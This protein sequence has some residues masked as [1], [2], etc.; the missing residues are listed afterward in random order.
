[1]K[2]KYWSEDEDKTIME[3]RK[4]GASWGAVARALGRESPTAV[5]NRWYRLRHGAG[6]M[7]R[8]QN[9]A[10]DE[11]ELIRQAYLDSQADLDALANELGRTVLAVKERAKDLG[12]ASRLSKRDAGDGSGVRKCHD[13][14]REAHPYRCPSCLKRWRAKNGLPMDGGAK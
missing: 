11:D 3:M 4:S 9:W 7:T 5:A 1:M 12:C 2:G 8:A 13:C 6:A 10:W 14:G